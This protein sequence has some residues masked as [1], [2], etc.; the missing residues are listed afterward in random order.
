LTI[1]NTIELYNLDWTK[2]F[3]TGVQHSKF[4]ITDSTSKYF[5]K[6][7]FY[8]GSANMDWRSLSEVKELGKKLN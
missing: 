1:N 3:S 5:L 8:L 4:I 2:A 6:I 7:D